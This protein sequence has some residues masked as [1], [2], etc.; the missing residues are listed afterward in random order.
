[1]S[2]LSKNIDMVVSGVVNILS[3]PHSFICLS[4]FD[5]L[6]D[7][8]NCKIFRDDVDDYCRGDFADAVMLKRLEDA[9]AHN[10][11]ILAVVAGFGRNHFGN[12]TSITISDAFA[13]KR[14]FKKVMRNAQAS[15]NDVSYVEMHGTGTQVIFYTFREIKG[16]IIV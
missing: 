4:D 5:V 8:S 11:N 2:L 14:L 6:F 3:W 15:L 7:T 10:D 12:S 9:V 13:Q 1:M 16:K